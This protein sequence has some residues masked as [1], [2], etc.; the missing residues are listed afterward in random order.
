MNTVT[1][2]TVEIF[3][4]A[5]DFIK[6]ED[7][8][9]LMGVVQVVFVLISM[10]LVDV[11]GRKTLLVGSSLVMGICLIALGTYF[12]IK[13]RKEG[14]EK[15]IAWLPVLSIY[16]YMAAY[17]TG[18]GPVPWVLANEIYNPDFRGMAKLVKVAQ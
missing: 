7:A 16:T 6:P 13:E 15:A 10:F 4:N 14:K 2:Y 17:G 1:F 11:L 5:G 9:M 8:T 3:R 12:H 18:M